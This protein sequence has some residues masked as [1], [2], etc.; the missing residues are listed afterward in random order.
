MERKIGSAEALSRA[1]VPM[2]EDRAACEALFRGFARRETAVQAVSFVNVEGLVTCS[3]EGVTDDWS[4]WPLL[5]GV[6]QNPRIMVN[7]VEMGRIT[8]KPAIIVAA[9]VLSPSD[10]MLGYVTM[11]L[12]HTTLAVST[13][14]EPAMGRPLVVATFNADGDI[15]T[16]TA[17][18]ATVEQRLP[19][20]RALKAF[21]GGRPA[22]FRDVDDTGEPRIYTITPVI[23]GVV[24]S[25][26]VWPSDAGFGEGGLWRWT[27][28]TIVLPFLMWATS[29]AV[30]FFAVHRL[31]I[32][33]VRRLRKRMRLF[34]RFRRVEEQQDDAALP[35]ELRE[36]TDSFVR[37]AHTILRDE[38]EQENSLRE[39]DALLREIYH[40]VRNNLQLIASI[41]NIQIRALRSPEARHVLRRLQDRIMALATIHGALYEAD[42]LSKVRADLLVKELAAQ[43]TLKARDRFPDL[44]LRS[45]TTP[46]LLHPDQAVPLALLVVEAVTNAVTHLQKPRPDLPPVLG[47]TLENCDSGEIRLLVENTLGEG[48]VVDAADC[49]HGGLGLQL[50]NAFVTQL[51]GGKNVRQTEACYRLEV[52]FAA[53]SYATA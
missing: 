36:V 12:D 8:G 18:A 20:N 5:D 41:N 3:S 35:V 50:M 9:P 29:L 48:A 15:L 16:S 40:R 17:D 11:P 42:V 1:V 27:V 7:S 39:K 22:V 13:A 33:H 30:A 6:M 38:A 52:R 51:G 47:V 14:A 37:M 2:L 21:V 19:M 25:V 32:R 53:V 45:E 24:Y 46:V 10:E 43:I 28:P 44:D 49:A 23:D 4:D 26:A 34:S 31:V